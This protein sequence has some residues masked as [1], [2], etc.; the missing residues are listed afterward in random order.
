MEAESVKEQPS[1]QRVVAVITPLRRQYLHVKRQYPDAILLFRLGD[2]YET[3]DRDA[4]LAARELEI[5]LT[6]REMGKG[7]RVPM[8]GIPYHALDSYLARLVKKGHKV[9][10][11]EQLTDPT[12]GKGLVERDVVRV[13]TPG[14][15]LEPALLEQKA[16]NYLVAVVPGESDAGLAY[17][18]ISTGEFAVSQLP[19]E[20]LAVELERLS[21][22]ELLLAAGAAE[23]PARMFLGLRS[24]EGGAA[25]TKL[26]PEDSDGE[27]ARERL[28]EHLGVTTLAGFGCDSLPLAVR[29]AGAIVAYLGRT[30]KTALA[31][32]TALSTYALDRTVPLDAQT[33]RN[34]E[35]F[36][37]GRSGAEHSL[38][39]EL[40]TTRTPMGGRLLRTWL[41]QPLRDL[42]D[43]HRRQEVVQ[44]FVERGL[45]REQVRKLLGQVGDVERI[46]ARV[47]AGVAQPR[48]LVA[49]RRGLDALP[50]LRASLTTDGLPGDVVEQLRPC[51]EV[52]ALLAQALVAEPNAPLGEGGVIREGFSPELD[53]LRSASRSATL[54]LA[55]LEQRER[56]RTGISALKVGYNRVFGYYLEVT[57]PHL[58]KVPSDFI[59]RQTLVNAE[60]FITPELKEH[61]ATVLGAQ[62]RMAELEAAL[63]RQVCR[64][65]ALQAPR[66]LATARAVAGLD[67]LA[68][69][70]DTAAR[71]G[72]SRPVL[73]RGP[74][75]RIKD[76][77]HPVVERVLPQ[78][79]FV[80]NDLELGGDC[81]L[82]VLTGP[83]MGGKSTF[84]RQAALIV[85]MAQIGSFVPAER[86]E[87]GLVDRIFTRMGL[88][89]DVTTGLSTFMVE[90]VET[91]QIL[92]N[93]TS[94][95]LVILDE[96]GRGTSTYDGLAIARA[97]AEHLHSSPRLGCKTLFA[98]HYH[99]LTELASDRGG[100][101]RVR[102]F[103]MSAV[104]QD[105]KLVFLHRVQP[106]GADRSYGVHVAQLAG[107]PRMVVH[108]AG[109]LLTEL[110][111]GRSPAPGHGPGLFTAKGGGRGEG[112][113][114]ARQAGG[115]GQGNEDQGAAQLPLLAEAQAHEVL[116]ALAELDLNGMTPLEALNRLYELQRKAKP[117]VD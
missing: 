82:I 90:M 2:F 61:E 1:E 58:A 28:Q 53:E 36:Q 16:N 8:A 32:L 106:G 114:L 93:V 79:T 81:T 49:L 54:Y 48:E 108:R 99:E 73:N 74:L 86:A 41:G 63:F 78:G 66:L 6:S 60:R 75:I 15:V 111:A 57:N 69:F 68:S 107:L 26:D 85:L 104:E 95:S 27:L 76:G 72:Y 22:A 23:G 5:V 55:G 89:D 70:A 31:Q 64:Q 20:R 11:C 46:V 77:R 7:Q 45:V 19:L 59:R 84:L 43:L 80:P 35:L 71:R 52:T 40:D 112:T 96:I 110:E 56:E 100:L 39:A 4:E 14:T 47:Q 42:A 91:A 83:N 12:E 13:V 24:G 17:A 102:N 113:R 30:Q 34:L 25:I 87:I 67:V 10:I 29:A 33:R 44:W 97:V 116:K 94:A 101:P 50:A 117:P 62:E 105:G 98:T 37:A 109:D 115:R 3:F 92:H 38:L 51:D 65:V 103:N 21:P 88:Q 9:A 18:D